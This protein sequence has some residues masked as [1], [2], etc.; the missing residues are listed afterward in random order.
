MWAQPGIWSMRVWLPWGACWAEVHC[1]Q[2]RVPGKCP[3]PVQSG[4]GA[5]RSPEAGG[6]GLCVGVGTCTFTCGRL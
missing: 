2:N 6:G 1:A 3:P 5:Q 4:R